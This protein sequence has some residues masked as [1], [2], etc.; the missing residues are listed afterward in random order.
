VQQDDQSPEIENPPRERP[1]WARWLPSWRAVVGISAFAIFS[2]IATLCAIYATVRIPPTDQDALAQAAIITYA[3]GSVLARL[4]DRNRENVKLEQVPGPVRLAVLAAEDHSFYSNGGV[5]PKSIARAFLSNV[6]GGS[7]GGSTISQQYVKN[8]YDQRERSLKRKF[9]EVFLAVKINRQ[10]DKDAI[11][12]RYLNT[13]Y[14]GRRA[15]GIQSAAQAYFHRDVDQLTVSQGAFLAGIINAPALADPRAGATQRQRAERRWAVVLDAMVKEGWLDART[16][17]G[18]TFPETVPPARD[19]AMKG[20]TGYLV[21]M[22]E[23]E[24]ERKLA[25]TEEQFRSGGYKIVTTFD[26][27]LIAAEIAAVKKSLPKD[28]P[29]RLQIGLAAVDPSTGAV[30][31]IYGGSDFLKR[32]QNTATQDN[33]E[34]AGTFSTFTLLAALN[35]GVSLNSV[36]NGGTPMKIGGELIHNYQARQYGYVNLF[37][38]TEQSVNTVFAQL[39]QQVGGDRTRETAYAAGIPKKADVGVGVSNA[40]GSDGLPAL[41][42][43]GAYATLAAE[44][45][46]R[47]PYVVQSVTRTG[48]GQ[49]A[50]EMDASSTKGKRAFPASAV[51]DTSFALEQVVR[52]GTGSYAARLRRPVA[53]QTGTSASSRS[54]W[55]VGYTPQLATAVSMYQLSRD[56]KDIQRMKGF[57]EFKSVFGGGYP[58]R[59]WTRF[60]TEAL[61]GRPVAA[62]PPPLLGGRQF[63][64]DPAGQ[65]VYGASR[66]DRL[67]GPATR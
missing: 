15:F 56:G 31:A 14:L 17:Q 43:A 28:K 65:L 57:G 38:A 64:G 53:A 42:L 16:R 61:S 41:D 39:N 32:Q 62:F 21:S 5:E 37:E 20:Q 6:R 55:F 54:A 47:T 12:E 4:G 30:R 10:M 8:V 44:G 46:R 3:D 2:V 19:G 35:D 23:A 7:Q 40:L 63:K 67:P 1:R 59:I 18:L 66:P 26:R 34:V 36:Y 24:V 58:A 29:K 9:N 45:M 49:V 48:T 33:V 25:I 27:E 50:L 60:M 22:A 11:L 52:T 13:I 51:A